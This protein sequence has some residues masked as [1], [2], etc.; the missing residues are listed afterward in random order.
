[1]ISG[2]ALLL[3]L[4]AGVVAAIRFW[5]K[6]I[7]RVVVMVVAM[8]TAISCRAWAAPPHEHLIK[9]CLLAQSAAPSV[10]IQD[11]DAH[12]VSQEDDYADGF[13]AS[14]LVGF[15]GADVGYA[16]G[17]STQA[18]VYSGKLYR[19]S[20]ALPVGNNGGIKPVAFNPA[21]AQWSLVTEGRQSY[22]CVSFNF[23]GLGR[24]GSFQN[25]HGGYLLN[26]ETGNLYFVVRDVRK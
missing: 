1:M 12:E 10:A 16:E 6:R 21:L 19:L 5:H 13:N 7:T 3:L 14:Y 4:V 20:A 15:E 2:I 25:V 9:S 24:S 11:I 22:L 17:K 23:D 8:V 18:L 26:P